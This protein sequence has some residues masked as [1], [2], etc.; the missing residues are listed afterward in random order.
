MNM[1]K[2]YPAGL[3]HPV[4]TSAVFCNLLHVVT[5]NTINTKTVDNGCNGNYQ[6]QSNLS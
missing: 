4:V 5:K 2:S 1:R 3:I 6:V